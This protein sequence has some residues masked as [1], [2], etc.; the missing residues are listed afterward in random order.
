MRG[1]VVVARRARPAWRP[2]HDVD[3]D[4]QAVP[5]RQRGAAVAAAVASRWVAQGPRVRAFEAAWA[6]RVAPPPPSRRRAARRRCTLGS[7]ASGAPGRRGDRALA[8]VRRH[9]QRG[10]AVRRDA[11]V[12]GHRPRD[13]QP[14]PGGRRA[15]RSRRAPARSCRCIRS[16]S[17]RHGRVPRRWPAPRTSS[18]SR[19]PR[20]RSAPRT[21]GGPVGSLPPDRVL[22]AAPAEGRSRPARAGW[23]R[24]RIPRRRP[25]AAA[26]APRH[27]PLR[28]RAPLGL[29]RGDRALSRAGLEYRMTDMQAA[30]G[31]CQLEVLDEILD[32]RRELADRYT[33]AVAEMPALHAPATRPTASA[34][35][36]ATASVWSPAVARRA[37]GADAAPSRR[38]DRH[39][40][41]RHGH[42]PGGCLRLGH[43]L[44]PSA[45]R[46]RGGRIYLMLPMQLSDREQDFVI[47]QLAAHTASAGRRRPAD[48]P[49]DGLGTRLD[50][51][52][53]RQHSGS[54]RPTRPR[55]SRPIAR[56]GGL[57]VPGLR[58]GRHGRAAGRPRAAV[59]ADHSDHQ[60]RLA[61]AASR[62][63]PG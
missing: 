5:D 31:L 43:A 21:A 38:R 58:P 49:G 57:R 46:R 18:S 13:A 62:I 45:Q 32:R 37:N 39:P 4:L 9:R 35:G 10:L 33:A 3:P 29:R 27:G 11:G 36:S 41:R 51:Q 48:G 19:M 1:L 34:R 24:H 53:Q 56:G 54:G 60:D 59:R 16:A 25:L 52:D 12:R 40:P 14:R 55:P 8:V 6:A 47:E 23:S 2:P 28:P 7:Y 26:P 30:L 50:G 42:P 61:R 63:R 17:R 22:L 44:R 20:A 15:R